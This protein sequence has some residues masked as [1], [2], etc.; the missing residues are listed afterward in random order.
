MAKHK[1]AIAALL[2][3]VGVALAQGPIVFS[4]PQPGNLQPVEINPAVVP[5]TATDVFTQDVWI[6]GGWFSCSAGTPTITLSDKQGSPVSMIPGVNPF[7]ACPGTWFMPAGTYKFAG[8]L[9]WTASA[10]GVK[11]YL[12]GR[13]AR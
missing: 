10:A 2:V 3:I 4:A 5:I 12:R 9:T 1:I 6:E 11:G 13:T 7:T 8:G